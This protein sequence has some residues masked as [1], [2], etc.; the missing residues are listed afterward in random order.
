MHPDSSIM[1]VGVVVY[2]PMPR[3]IFLEGPWKPFSRVCS[4]QL[5]WDGKRAFAI[6]VVNQSTCAV[7]KQARGLGPTDTQVRW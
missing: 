2:K 6:V 3:M 5:A 1:F 7:S 4:T